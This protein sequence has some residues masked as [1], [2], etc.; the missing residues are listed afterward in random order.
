MD[1]IDR[2]KALSTA[3]HSRIEHSRTEE[4]TK[5]ALVMPFLQELGYN[6]FD[7]R[8]VVPEYVAGLGVKRAEK[9]DYAIMKH[10]KPII[11]L[12]CKAVGTPLDLTKVTQLFRYFASTPARFGVLTDGMIYRFF[13]DL[14]EPNKMDEKPFLEFDLSE[15]TE[16]DAK[17]LKRFTRD[18]FD[19]EDSLRAAE[20]LKYTAAIKWMFA[21]M[22]KRPSVA[23]VKLVID[24]V[25]GGIKTKPRI[26]KF[27]DLT[28]SAF[29]E[30]IN[31]RINNR[32]QSALERE[33]ND[34]PDPSEPEE[35]QTEPAPQS[36]IVTT[37]EELQGYAIVKELL[38]GIV[39]EGRI[40]LKD[41]I[42]YC[43]VLLDGQPTRPI[44]RFRF[45]SKNK[46]I[47]IRD[48]DNRDHT[49]PVK[50]VDGIR[51]HTEELRARLERLLG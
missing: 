39:D 18:S 14:E 8:E 11:I 25:H 23:F 46:R 44:V 21:D 7:P 40:V 41:T 42:N 6:V 3:A 4:A 2:L 43:N 27:T 26:E 16:D 37:N 36:Q 10:S 13:S 32:L 24:Q 20:S 50:G 19:A 15:I 22:L 47:E 45:D 34:T 9:V 33:G 1:F 5:S 49:Y 38:A 29:R 30:F 28:R 48:E 17:N 35:H 12:E 51:E 31:E